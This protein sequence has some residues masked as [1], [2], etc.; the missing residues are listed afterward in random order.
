MLSKIINAWSNS[1][2]VDESHRVVRRT[3][4]RLVWS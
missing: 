2:R 3:A 4:E 1:Y